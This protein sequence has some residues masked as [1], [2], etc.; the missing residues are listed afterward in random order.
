MRKITNCRQ[1][2]KDVTFR[3]FTEQQSLQTFINCNKKEKKTFSQQIGKFS[4]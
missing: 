4:S 2:S 1:S 3:K